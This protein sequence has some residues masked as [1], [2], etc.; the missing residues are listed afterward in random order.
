MLSALALA[1]LFGTP[2][3]VL[4]GC[5]RAR[6]A[7]AWPW[8]RGIAVGLAFGVA[9]AA[10]TATALGALRVYSFAAEC[11]VVASSTLVVAAACGFRFAWPL[12]RVPLAE[13]CGFV[14]VVALASGVILGHPF[15]MLLG[16]RD[17]T[18]YTVSGIGLAREGSLVLHDHTADVIGADAMRHFY[19]GSGGSGKAAQRLL[20]MPQVVKYPGFYYVDADRREIVAQGLPLLPALIAIFYG[21]F[22][23]GGAFVANNAI[24]VLAVGSVFA[25]GSALIGALGATVGATLL[26]LDAIEVWASRYPVAEIL[27]QALLF[28][29]FAAYLRA[30]RLGRGLAGFLLGATLLAKV[31]AALILLPIGG[32]ALLALARRRPG[33]GRSFWLAYAGI[34]LIAASYWAFFEGDYAHKA[35]ASFSSLQS[36]LLGNYFA[37]HGSWVVAAM[38]LV[39]LLAV[40]GFVRQ[41]TAV[42]RGL[43]RRVAR[44]L[45]VGVVLFAVFGYWVRPHLA[46]LVVGQGKTLVWLSWYVSPAVLL[47]GFAG[48]AH[49]LWMRASAENLFVLGILLTLASVF[50]HFTFVNLIHIYMTRRF[51]PAALPMVLLFFG[52]AVTTLGASGTGRARAAGALL[53]SLLAAGAVFTV[54]RRSRPLYDHREYPGLSQRFTDLAASLRGEDIVFLSDGKAR[55]LLGPALEFVFGARTLVVWPPAYDRQRALIRDWIDAGTAIGALTVTEQLEDVPG[56]EAFDLIERPVWWMSALAQAE[57]RFPTETAQ[58]VTTL[59]R[60]AAGRG[61]DP[62]YELWK[63]EGSRITGVLCGDGVRLLGGNRFLVRRVHAGCPA[64][65]VSG[66]TMGYLVGDAESAAWQEALEAYGARFV[67]RDLGGVVLFDQIAPQPIGPRLSATDWTL[68]ATHG[69]GSERLAVDGSLDTRWGS[70]APQRPGMRFTVRFPKPTDV[71]WLKIRMGQL[72]SDRARRLVLETSIDGEH[73]KR[74]ELPTV[75]DGMRWQDGVPEE[76]AAGDLDL[77]VNVRGVRA[78][79]LVNDGESSRFDWSIA[80]LEIYG[81]AG[82]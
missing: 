72:T 71:S 9:L 27:F 23:L 6:G 60:Y 8:P 29:G 13:S 81:R 65:G 17:A 2:G 50:L 59:A 33:P 63:R 68:E 36:R 44:G 49:Y 32:Y 73:W 70:H 45:A 11:A 25:A 67:R 79:S 24:G 62:L 74:Q 41:S 30:D 56:A 53:A 55:N 64:S 26:A 66:R 52:Y 34:A 1:L 20:R 15:E 7:A 78:L 5:A 4:L 77:W 51:V 76:N 58:D 3:L 80:E 57:D 31:E 40:L 21:A 18:V 43:S 12:T 39:T 42:S 19:P 69:R 16:E 48:L 46:G 10:L 82:S 14:V 35:Y 61:S 22:G 28:A 38:L 54:V 75:I 47:L 37:W